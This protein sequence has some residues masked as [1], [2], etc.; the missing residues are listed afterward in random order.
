[1]RPCNAYSS[2]GKNK[3]LSRN[4]IKQERGKK[5][6]K[7]RGKGSKGNKQTKKD[8][9]IKGE[10]GFKKTVQLFLNRT[11]L[12]LKYIYMTISTGLQKTEKSQIQK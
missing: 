8:G 5:G 11:F 6:K 3:V 4:K 7:E 9:E 10:Q 2:Y 12:F 1:M